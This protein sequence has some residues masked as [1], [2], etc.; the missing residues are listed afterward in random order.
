MPFGLRDAPATFQRLVDKML[1]SI[2]YD[3]VMAYLDDIIVKG[4]EVT[5]SMKNL[6]E[7]FE[8]IREAGL[9]LKPSKCEL[10]REE[11]TYLGHII[12]S[13]GLKTDPK[14]VEAVKNWPIPIYITDVRG[15]IG[16]C[17]YYRRFI[18]GF[19]EQVKV[20]SSL[21]KKDSDRVWREEHTEAF[22]SMKEALTTTPL[23]S[24]P[25]EGREYILDTDASTWAIGAVLS[26]M[27]PNAKGDLEERPIAYASRL[28]LPRELNYCTRPEVYGAY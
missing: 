20:L 6:R 7:V 17:S 22:E 25:Q 21:T 15:F 9:K 8:R 26:Q 14:K 3:Y 12:N 5:S 11:I 27:Q 13:K 28:L 2:Q 24:H 23:L 4:Q 10:L 19:G 18:K 16:L 1:T